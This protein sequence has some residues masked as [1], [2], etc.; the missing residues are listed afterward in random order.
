MAHV[1]RKFD[2]VKLV[3]YLSTR[4]LKVVALSATARS[5]IP[6]VWREMYYNRLYI[7]LFSLTAL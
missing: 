4:N 3:N 1:T 2:V 6:G 7:G 5:A